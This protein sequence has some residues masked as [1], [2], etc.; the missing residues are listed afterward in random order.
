VRASRT[1]VPRGGHGHE[2]GHD[3]GRAVARAF[4]WWAQ[5][6]SREGERSGVV[7]AVTGDRKGAARGCEMGC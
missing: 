1:E 2:Q 4:W 3:G 5:R 7:V 6:G